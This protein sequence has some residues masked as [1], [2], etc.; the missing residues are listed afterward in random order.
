MRTELGITHLSVDPGS[1]ARIEIDVT[2]V[3]EVIDGVTAIVDG[4]DQTWIRFD[5][6]VVSL[7]PSVTTTIGFTIDLP[8]DCPAG[9][10][11]VVV[12][13]V[14]TIDP[15]RQSVHDFWISVAPV[16]A[17][18]L[19]L[20]PRVI[21]SGSSASIEATVVNEGNVDAPVF[22]TA[23]DQT[24]E[25]D[26]VVEP[27]EV[28]VP[29]GGE[30][31][32]GIEVHGPR[33]WFGQAPVRTISITAVCG[34]IEVEELATFTQKPRIARGLVTALILAGIILL[35]ATIF[36]LVVAAL[37]S[38]DDPAKATAT[39]FETGGA[40]NVALAAIAGTTE[41]QVTAATTGEGVP[42]ITVEAFRVRQNGELLASGSAATDDDGAYSL[43][44]LIPGTYV[45]RFSSDGF[46]EVW[47]PAGSS[48]EEAEPVTVGPTETVSDLDV[49]LSGGAGAL[50][51]VITVPETVEAA[52]TLS[53]TA[54]LLDGDGDGDGDGAGDDTADPG[55]DEPAAAPTFTQETQGDFRLD[56]LPTPG[57]YRIRVEG[58]D[59]EPQVL[60]ESLEGGE[61]K[62][63]NT[64]RMGAAL[65][66][67]SGTVVD[68]EGTPLGN[69]VVTVT[70]GDDEREV[71][72][73]TSG[74]VGEFQVI[75]LETPST[76]VL[77]FELE[78]YSGETIALDVLAGEDRGGITALLIGGNGSV[79]GTVRDTEGAPLGDV[80]VTLAGDGFDTATTTLTAGDDGGG[81]G[82]YSL[83]GIPVPG[84]Y[85]VT[86]VADG[87][88]SETLEVGFLAAGPAPPTDVELR[89]DIGEIT[90]T[91]RGG[92][93]PL[94]DVGVEL[95][96]G[97]EVRTSTTA[98]APA[99]VFRFDGVGPG[100][101]T[102]RV[103]A[104]AYQERV[105]LVRVAEGEVLTRDI[106][107]VPDPTTVGG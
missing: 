89:S 11:L 21:T 57:T 81:V 92:A 62:V 68:A 20:R 26:C 32:V 18:G 31:K 63:L 75:G 94:G 13:V 2:N 56:G 105:V 55:T 46:D 19:D 12:R 14:S 85:T 79:S 15:E 37:S 28:I 30:A 90:G 44:S 67:I 69:V 27:P 8:S 4:I 74:N 84:V 102:L 88:V 95:S 7:F 10:Y 24:R 45:L 36:L 58:A 38:G 5:A 98:T 53:V 82:S 65:G 16:V 47:Y 103:Q 66:S 54:T 76:Y 72:T 77:T 43:S 29:E 1:P 33:P 3:S 80:E 41:G 99:G 97:V 52:P 48:A 104:P 51:G 49:V 34:D 50:V 87:Y 59:F 71:T 93:E 25:A 64:I 107:L 96:D 61:V 91:V 22:V 17:F 73:P 39:D 60:E 40:A 101:Y 9:D 70:G 78:G 106:D 100:A 86:F 6:P 35:W 23:I 83:S 42:R